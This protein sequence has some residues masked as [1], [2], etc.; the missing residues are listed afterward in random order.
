MNRTTPRQLVPEPIHIRANISLFQIQQSL[1]ICQ[2]IGT[3]NLLYRIVNLCLRSFIRLS[4]EDPI[5]TAL[6]FIL[7]CSQMFTSGAP[8]LSQQVYA[9]GLRHGQCI[10]SLWHTEPTDGKHVNMNPRW[11]QSLFSKS[12]GSVNQ[13]SC[14]LRSTWLT[15]T[16][17]EDVQRT[18]SCLQWCVL[19]SKTF[20]V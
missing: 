12:R 1:Y 5:F 9:W 19:Q 6:E 2:T 8:L 10:D 17:L 18:P 13:G 15:C 3:E 20:W 14:V 16:L 4:L 7:I 11:A